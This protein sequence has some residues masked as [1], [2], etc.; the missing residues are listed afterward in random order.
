M[1][2]SFNPSLNYSRFTRAASIELVRYSSWRVYYA[3]FKVVQSGT[4][5]VIDA[6][7]R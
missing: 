4:L 7:V 1:N 2:I 6:F 5:A 3:K